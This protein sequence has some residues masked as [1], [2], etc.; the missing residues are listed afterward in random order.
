MGAGE[1]VLSTEGKEAPSV[2]GVEVVESSV[3]FGVDAIQP[4]GCGRWFS[5]HI[6]KGKRWGG[7]IVRNGTRFREV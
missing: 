3:E 7:K 6:G 4:W 5:R 2:V 1:V